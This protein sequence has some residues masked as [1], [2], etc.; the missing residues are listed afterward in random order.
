MKIGFF[1]FLII[2]IFLDFEFFSFPIF[3][4]AL[5]LGLISFWVS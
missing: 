3:L 1:F 5:S 2:I 4:H